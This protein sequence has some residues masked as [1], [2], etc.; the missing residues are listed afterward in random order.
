MQFKLK[1]EAR[2][3]FRFE[4][5]RVLV[6]SPQ[7]GE[8]GNDFLADGRDL[9]QFVATQSLAVDHECSQDGRDRR[10]RVAPNVLRSGQVL[11]EEF[12]VTIRGKT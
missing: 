12:W 3:G 8:R 2:H 4:R 1:L 6:L 9:T 11:A 7:I 5:V 10:R